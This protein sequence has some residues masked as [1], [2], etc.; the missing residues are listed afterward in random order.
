MARTVLRQIRRAIV[1]YSELDTKTGVLEGTA[2]RLIVLTQDTKLETFLRRE[3]SAPENTFR[4]SKPTIILTTHPVDMIGVTMDFSL[5]I[6]SA[7]DRM[8][9]GYFAV[10]P[11]ESERRARLAGPDGICFR[12]T[13]QEAS[14]SGRTALEASASYSLS[15]RD[16][17][18]FNFQLSRAGHNAQEFPSLNDAL[19]ADDWGESS[20]PDDDVSEPI[21]TS[22]VSPRREPQPLASWPAYEPPAPEP[23]KELT[24]TE[25]LA[26]RLDVSEST[27][28]VFQALEAVGKKD[29]AYAVAAVSRESRI[30]Q[31][32]HSAREKAVK[33]F[34][35]RS[36]ILLRVRALLAH[37]N[38]NLE[39]H[40]IN[41]ASLGHVEAILARYGQSFG[42]WIDPEVMTDQLRDLSDHELAKLLAQ[43]NPELFA[44]RQEGYGYGGD[45]LRYS[46]STAYR[47]IGKN[48]VADFTLYRFDDYEDGP[49]S[50][51]FQ[52]KQFTESDRARLTEPFNFGFVISSGGP[53][54][55]FADTIH[56]V[57]VSEAIELMPDKVRRSF[58]EPKLDG[59]GG[60]YRSVTVS[61]KRLQRSGWGSWGNEP[62]TEDWDVVEELQEEVR[63]QVADDMIAAEVRRV[64]Q[65]KQ[66]EAA[67]LERWQAGS[68]ELRGRLERV[69]IILE[70]VVGQSPS[71]TTAASAR[72]ADVR[73]L[74]EVT[75][76]PAGRQSLEQITTEVERHELR[77][78]T[79]VRKVSKET[80]WQ[81]DWPE[82]FNNLFEQI[83]ALVST[84][85]FAREFIESDE[86]TAVQISDWIK[87]N[88]LSSHL[89]AIQKGNSVDIAK[90]IEAAVEQL[91]G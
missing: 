54:G 35:T 81:P 66:V 45:E 3:L 16:R 29:L 82:H 18:Q 71:S 52:R 25:R 36:D 56:P 57:T 41:Q 20:W 46:M 58:G 47:R 63:G 72:L 62:D 76:G 42:D 11:G 30:V 31:T 90:L 40:G 28:R 84:D 91:V 8:G 61:A 87:D 39:D 32:E 38:E 6:D 55:D 4:G 17:E 26:Q 21:Y 15:P 80:G 78:A 1:G 60:V 69:A 48:S 44:Y 13:T 65:E 53:N 68:G 14:E 37:R 64:E 27:A 77:T 24:P 74:L 83:P 19:G 67:R 50:P 49:W 86:V 85:D 73:K 2:H 59:R 5:V 89:P 51:P 33:R 23:P 70:Q 9:G 79:L 88:I 12:L 34:G 75:N 10:S 7:R 43:S 22:E